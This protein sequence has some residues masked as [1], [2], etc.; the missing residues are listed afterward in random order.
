M[1][2]RSPWPAKDACQVTNPPDCSLGSGAANATVAS[3]SVPKALDYPG[4]G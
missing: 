3:P 4:D 1:F 2:S